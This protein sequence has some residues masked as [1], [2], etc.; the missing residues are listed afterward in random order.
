MAGREIVPKNKQQ[1]SAETSKRRDSIVRNWLVRLAAL[2]NRD[3]AAPIFGIWFDTLKD[4]KPDVVG[5]AFNRVEKTFVPT[6]ACPFPT[7]AHVRAFIDEANE[8]SK[9]V[10]AEDTWNGALAA[11]E[12]QY[13]PDVGWRGPTLDWRTEHALR[14]AGGAHF[15]SQCPGNDLVW[16][17]K[18]FL[19][20]YLR[21]EQLQ[22][23]FELLGTDSEIVK[24][25]KSIADKKSIENL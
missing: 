21:D 3:L 24:T 15:I 20:C 1:E 10:E 9:Q 22:S 4:L 5:I 12:K 8:N 11:I 18:R 19:E 13:H 23:D 7:P 6:S 14:A 17:K 16:A 2:Y 25:I